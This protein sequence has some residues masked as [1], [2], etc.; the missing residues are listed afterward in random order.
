MNHFATTRKL[1]PCILQI[2][3]TL[4]RYKD[5]AYLNYNIMIQLLQIYMFIAVSEDYFDC[6]SQYSAK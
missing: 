1:I 6:H 5:G 3:L 4:S 2:S